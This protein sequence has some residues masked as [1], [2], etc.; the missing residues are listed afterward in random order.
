VKPRVIC[1]HL[2]LA[3]AVGACTATTT[4]DRDWAFMQSVGGL[5]IGQ[6]HRANEKVY[7]P[8]ACDVSGLTTIT[9]KP[10]TMNSGLVVRDVRASRR[11]AAVYIWVR[12]SL[13]H[14]K[15]GQPCGTAELGD[16]PPGKYTVYYGK[17][18]R[19][20]VKPAQKPVEIGAIEVEP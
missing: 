13:P 17:P 7:L 8:V 4:E 6:P 9:V 12:T 1:L 20:F 10:T 5:S 16:L 14:G 18:P 11:G 15:D 3:A 2:G 19:W